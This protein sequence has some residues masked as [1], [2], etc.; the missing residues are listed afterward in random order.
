M[1]RFLS[2]WQN[3][4]KDDKYPVVRTSL[5]V[6]VLLLVAASWIVSA[7]INSPSESQ[8]AGG[9]YESTTAPATD[10]QEATVFITRTGS[11]YHRGGCRYLSKS[12]IPISLE[13]A[14]RRYSPCSVCNPP[15]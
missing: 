12:K 8:S 11:K 5:I 4:W 2:E 6:G 7:R 10:T 15:R 3:F 14:K 9:S 1:D 13:N